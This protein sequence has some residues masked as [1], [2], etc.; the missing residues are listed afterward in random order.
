MNVTNWRN[1]P[2]NWRQLKVSSFERADF[3]IPP[4]PLHFEGQIN[5]FEQIIDGRNSCSGVY[6]QKTTLD[7]TS[8]NSENRVQLVD[9]TVILLYI[10]YTY[11]YPSLTCPTL[12]SRVSL[13]FQVRDIFSRWL[14]FVE[15]FLSLRCKMRYTVTAQIFKFVFFLLI[16]I[17]LSTKLCIRSNLISVSQWQKRG[18]KINLMKNR[19]PGLY[20]VA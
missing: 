18:Q 7:L 13:D 8:N 15:I 1:S 20:K 16:L 3:L 19:P 9:P 10:L 12:F 2:V 6:Q 11:K 5:N 14:A 4:S 17:A